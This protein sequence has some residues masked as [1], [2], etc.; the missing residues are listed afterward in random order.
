MMLP[1]IELLERQFRTHGRRC[2]TASCSIDFVLLHEEPDATPA[3]VRVQIE[4]GGISALELAATG[5]TSPDLTVTAAASLIEAFLTGQ[6]EFSD[7]LT[8]CGLDGDFWYVALFTGV[9]EADWYRSALAEAD[10][11]RRSTAV[12]GLGDG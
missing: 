12:K 10:A 3:V 6:S 8:E 2:P 7:I 4:E 1:P 9:F 11:V 5:S